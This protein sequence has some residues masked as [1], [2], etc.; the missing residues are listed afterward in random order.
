MPADSMKGETMSKTTRLLAALG[1]ITV[2]A[3]GLAGLQA[4]GAPRPTLP[5]IPAAVA[6]PSAASVASTST[7]S[8]D[9]ALLS[10][11]S[12]MLQRR[13]GLST[14]EAD[15][16]AASMA[17]RMQAVGGSQTAAMVNACAALGDASG[18][19]TGPNG[20]GG[21]MGGGIGTNGAGYG[22]MMGGG[23]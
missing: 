16:L 15:K 22:S 4:F 10:K 17:Q 21:M 5:T 1:F 14:A 9:P 7:S 13:M 8:A 18:N 20:Y 3:L 2:G 23:L 11:I 6:A 19:T 12:D